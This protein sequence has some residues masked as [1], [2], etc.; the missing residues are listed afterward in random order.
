[1]RG[2]RKVREFEGGSEGKGKEEGKGEERGE[3][4]RQK[5]ELECVKEF[6]RVKVKSK[7]LECGRGKY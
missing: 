4:M 1:M 6:V 7:A 2:E 5:F 3:S